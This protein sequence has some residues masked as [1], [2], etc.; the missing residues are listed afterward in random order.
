MSRMNNRNFISSSAI[1][2]KI[3]YAADYDENIT[4]SDDIEKIYKI[5]GLSNRKEI[6][7][8]TKKEHIGIYCD[9]CIKKDI[10]DFI[11]G[12][13]LNY[14]DNVKYRNSDICETCYNSDI[15]NAIDKSIYVPI[16]PPE[17]YP[18][19][20]YEIIAAKF[21]TDN[22]FVYIIH[23]ENASNQAN[24]LVHYYLKAYNSGKI[25]ADHELYSYN[26]YFG[27][28]VL[29]LDWNLDLKLISLDYIE[30]HGKYHVEIEPLDLTNCNV[31][32]IYF[33]D[34]AGEFKRFKS[35]EINKSLSCVRV[36]MI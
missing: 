36:D 1:L 25:V 34:K 32:P 27:I 18:G 14:F 33:G 10:Y 29:K 8:N 6:I 21:I 23:E 15:L 20:E 9:L 2:N 16:D 4:N 11:I 7:L 26:P 30:K 3:K 17:S 24:V 31:D 28:D 5:I 13:R 12:I 22:I 35:C 19:Y